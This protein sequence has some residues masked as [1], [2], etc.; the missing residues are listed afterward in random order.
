[1]Q[2]RD[3]A[4]LLCTIGQ[5]AADNSDTQLRY[6]YVSL[7]GQIPHVMQQWSAAPW[8]LQLLTV[9]VATLLQQIAASK[10]CH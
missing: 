8:G 2:E 6:S 5:W 7:L 10:A 4:A 9:T 1:L 3:K